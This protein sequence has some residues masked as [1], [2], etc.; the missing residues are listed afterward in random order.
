MNKNSEDIIRELKEIIDKFKE[1]N[2]KL[3]FNFIV[4]EQNFINLLSDRKITY[5][6]I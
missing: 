4:D 1:E 3:G 2:I 5:K 6:D